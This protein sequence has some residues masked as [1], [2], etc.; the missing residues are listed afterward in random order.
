[1]NQVKSYIIVSHFAQ[2]QYDSI[3]AHMAKLTAAMGEYPRTQHDTTS[4]PNLIRLI[5][6][7]N[8]DISKVILG[9]SSQP[10]RWTALTDMLVGFSTYSQ[11]TAAER[12]KSCCTAAYWW[13]ADPTPVP[14]K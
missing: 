2:K 10:V 8:T 5:Q 13:C 14:A 6:H 1:M 11:P 7:G 9:Q 4:Y 3:S 12:K